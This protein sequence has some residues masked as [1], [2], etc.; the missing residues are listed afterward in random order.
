MPQSTVSSQQQQTTTGRQIVAQQP[1]PYLV[2]IPF[3]LTGKGAR[4]E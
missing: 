3:L 1:I 4:H 2:Y